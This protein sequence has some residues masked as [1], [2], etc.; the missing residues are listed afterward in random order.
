M[1][2]NI[3]YIFIGGGVGSVL[4]YLVSYYGQKLCNIGVFPIGTLLV[5]IIGCFMMGLLSAYFLKVENSFKFLL[6]T[7]FCGGFTTFSAF[8]SESIGLWQASHYYLM[9][10][11][12]FSSVILGLIAV[13]A[14]SY[15]VKM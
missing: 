7:G 5:N 15:L 10:I 9:F 3:I 8:S 11:Y 6:I 14:G 13:L 12:I 1:F 4:R 2:N